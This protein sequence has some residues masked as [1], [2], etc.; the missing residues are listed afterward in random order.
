[1]VLIM[2]EKKKNELKQ[3]IK[4]LKEKGGFHTELVS[5]YMPYDKKIADVVNSLKNE[6]NQCQNIKQKLT[7]KNV[8]ES[9]K[10]IIG[11]VAKI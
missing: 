5:L 11:Q 9:I 4:M 1:M 6:L 10:S 3:H 8:S 2:N 7:R